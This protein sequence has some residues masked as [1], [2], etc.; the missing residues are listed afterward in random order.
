V[1]NNFMEIIWDGKKSGAGR[2]VRWGASHCGI[3][4]RLFSRYDSFRNR[5]Q[6]RR[7][8]SMGF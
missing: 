4:G 3:L 6:F 2:F 7:N 5:R 1:V 8:R